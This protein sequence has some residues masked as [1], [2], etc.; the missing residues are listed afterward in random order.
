MRKILNYRTSPHFEERIKQRHIDP[1]LVSMCLIKGKMKY[2]K[3]KK[4]EFTLTKDRIKD[5]IEQGYINVFDYIGLI[6]L[7][8]IVRS[9]ILITVFGR[10]G[11]TGLNY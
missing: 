10:Y 8:V 11:D 6:S 9:N 5:V 7:T 1:F 4:I 3:K 2:K